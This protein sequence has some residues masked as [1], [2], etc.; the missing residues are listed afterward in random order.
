MR[1]SSF[2]ALKTQ[3]PVRVELV[4]HY[5]SQGK[6]GRG[7]PAAGQ[8]D[9]VRVELERMPQ[10]EIAVKHLMREQQ[11]PAWPQG[12]AARFY[13]LKELRNHDA[14]QVTRPPIGPKGT[15]RGGPVSLSGR[16]RICCVLLG[17]GCLD[18]VF[19]SVTKG[20]EVHRANLH[21]LAEVREQNAQRQRGCPEG[22]WL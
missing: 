11:L 2:G 4:E 10:R 22:M 21:P 8:G 7:D 19:Y 15:Q 20:D 14:L 18:D 12:D 13:D 9:V 3:P 5:F 6:P 1:P 17:N 16:E